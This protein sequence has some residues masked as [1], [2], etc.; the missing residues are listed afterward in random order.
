MNLPAG[1]AVTVHQ[2]NRLTITT[3]EGYDE[4]RR[5]Y[6]QAVPAIPRNEMP[7][8]SGSWAEMVAWIDSIAPY[9]F[10][11]YFRIEVDDAMGLAGHTVRGTQYL[12]GN[13]TIVE[14]MFRHD[15]GVLLHAPLRTFLWAPE[16]GPTSLAV[17]QPSTVFAGY[18]RPEINEVGRELDGRLAVLLEHLGVPVP[19]VPSAAKRLD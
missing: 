8:H 6:E 2:V 13:H 14:R 3:T 9:G 5:R 7:A 1:L 19:E 11:S 15:P 17:E 16:G 4:F 18:G 12:M 10:V